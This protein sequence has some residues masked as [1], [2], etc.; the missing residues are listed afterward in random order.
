MAIV[1]GITLGLAGAN[2]QTILDN[3]LAS[4]IHLAYPQPPGSVPHWPS[5]SG[6]ECCHLRIPYSF[7]STHSCSR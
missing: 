3:P 6:W 2:M 7:R 4:H 1:I 5:C